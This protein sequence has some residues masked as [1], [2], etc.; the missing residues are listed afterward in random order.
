MATVTGLT[1][2]VRTTPSHFAEQ[3]DSKYHLQSTPSLDALLE[4][5]YRSLSN[6]ELERKK[7]AAALD[8]LVFCLRRLRN[9]CTKQQWQ[10]MI[11]TCRHHPLIELLHQDPFT[12]RAF[13]KPRGYAGDAQLLDYVYGREE[14]WPAPDSSPLGKRIFDYTTDAPAPQAV[15]AR[16]GFVARRIDRLADEIRQP[17]I[18]SVAAGHL[19]EAAMTA[20]VKRRLLGRF[21]ALDADADSLAE[22]ER[23]YGRFGV[24]TIAA[25]VRQCLT[26]RLDLGRYDFIYALGLLDY[27]G[28]LTGRRLISRL[29]EALQPGGQLL[30]A[31]FL[32]NVRD[33]GYMEAYMDWHLHYRTRQD[34]VEM[35]M[36][37][38]QADI[39]SISLVAEQNQSIIFLEVRR[40]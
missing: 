23:C 30:V 26:G 1:S 15:L 10:D 3:K 22:I 25:S 34:L 2:R 27:L 32:P 13:S 28:D 4:T 17:Q 39:E 9:G 19:R 31:N 24:E 16:R 29:F 14:L 33:V 18:L 20:A 21:T 35:T 8:H 12:F 37:I 7:P 6:S 5:T 36:E 11:L 40:N 38:P